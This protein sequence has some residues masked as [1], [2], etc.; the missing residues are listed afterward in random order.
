MTLDAS[1]CHWTGATSGLPA[2]AIQI[3]VTNATPDDG[4]FPLFV[5]SPGHTYADLATYLQGLDTQVHQDSHATIDVNPGMA[6]GYG[7]IGLLRSGQ[8]ASLVA[9]EIPSGSVAGIACVHADA[10]AGITYDVYAVGPLD[11]K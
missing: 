4:A 2:G 5:I 11:F 1:G 3:D 10:A 9:N 8:T 6:T 7:I